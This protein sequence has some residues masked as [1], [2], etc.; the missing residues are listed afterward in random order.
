M[1][2]YYLDQ[3][4]VYVMRAAHTRGVKVADYISALFRS[5]CSWLIAIYLHSPVRRRK[6]KKDFLTL[7]RNGSIKWNMVSKFSQCPP[8]LLCG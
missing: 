4:R 8:H 1:V 2:Y 7:T 3:Q 5:S 6:K